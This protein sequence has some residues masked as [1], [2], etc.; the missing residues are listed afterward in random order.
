M[1]KGHPD[2]EGQFKAHIYLESGRSNRSELPLEKESHPI[3]YGLS[4]RLRI[5]YPKVRITDLRVNGERV[6]VSPENGHVSWVARAFTYV[7]INIPPERS[8]EEDF[9][10][11]TCLYEPGEKR[12]FGLGWQ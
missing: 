9:F 5:P 12:V 3:E 10:V 8:R 11:V 7:Q 1:L 4:L 6:P 2:A